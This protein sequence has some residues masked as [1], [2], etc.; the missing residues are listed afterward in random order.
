[1]VLFCFSFALAPAVPALS[2]SPFGAILADTEVAVNRVGLLS[3]GYDA[4][5]L[6]VHLI[7]QAQVSIEVQT[8]IWSNDECGRLMMYELLEAARRGVKV[9]IIADSLFSEKD[10]D[11]AAFV[12]TANP[13]LEIKHYR[14]SL[15]RLKPTFLHTALATAQSFHDINQRMHN[16]V[17]LF[18]GKVLITGGRNIDNAYFDHSTVMNYRDR[19]VV[20]TGPAVESAS[21]V[22]EDFW[23]YKHVVA[24]RN[25][26]DVAAAI[27]KNTFRRFATRADYD[28][29][30]Y[31]SALDREANDPDIVNERFV[32]RLRPVQKA[33][34]ISD[35]PGKSLGFFS[36]SA[37]ITRELRKTLESAQE[38][39]VLQT[40]YLVLSNPAREVIR[41]MQ[42]RHPKL[43]ITVSSNSYAST[44]NLYAYS[45]NYRL[46]NRYVEDLRLRVFEYKRSQRRCRR[47]FPTTMRSL[48]S[49]GRGSPRRSR[50]AC[51]SFQFTR[52]PWS[53]TTASR[54]S[55][56]TIWIP[57]R[58]I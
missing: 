36:K 22:F 16:K 18:D 26:V 49:R 35:E 6:R 7:R 27:E 3:N 56:R 57:V 39:V 55:A 34:F 37:R 11:I 15:S 14:P 30:S 8:F 42:R 44:D 21:A 41:T 20:V 58:R 40:P 5:L 29:G 50:R 2:G 17:M 46:R 13:N 51:P 28:F 4:L 38:T 33:T 45:A 52:S 10:P 12:A 19:D 54:S 31:F 24:S 32:E 9:R 1:M 53:W 48:R 43:R 47:C 25:L 23:K